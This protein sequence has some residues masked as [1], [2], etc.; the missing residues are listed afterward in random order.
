MA[1]KRKKGG[2]K[3]TRKGKQ[4]SARSKT[5]KPSAN[6]KSTS[7]SKKVEAPKKKIKRGFA[8]NNSYNK[9]RSLIWKNNKSDFKSYRDTARIASAVY[10]DCQFITDCTPEDI[11]GYY[12]ERK[13]FT[14]AQPPVPT[15]SNALLVP[16]D[17]WQIADVPFVAFPK[18]LWVISPSLLGSPHEALGISISY[19]KYLRKFVRWCNLQRRELGITDSDEYVPQFIFTAPFWNE[20]MKRWETELFTCD[21]K[22]SPFDYG[23]NS[24]AIMD[25]QEDMT[26]PTE[27]PPTEIPVEKP[28]IKPPVAP[29]EFQVEEQRLRIEGLKA[30]LEAKKQNIRID[31]LKAQAELK[32]GERIQLRKNIRLLAQRQEKIKKDIKEMRD[33]GAPKELIDGLFGEYMAVTNKLKELES[34]LD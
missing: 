11:Q 33:L 17:F 12:I 14:Q 7:S 1:K 4:P 16:Q 20:A 8:S 2:A 21:E 13:G 25:E 24:D 18:Y 31:G 27:L 32:K 9:I 5:S 23:Y 28:P 3:S 6:K 19:T 15:I 29:I 26:Q 22:G 10:A 34:K 30:D